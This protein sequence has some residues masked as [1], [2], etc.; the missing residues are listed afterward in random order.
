DGLRQPDGPLDCGNSGT[1]MR[2]LAGVLAGRPFPATLTGD[3]S[4]SS[5][6]MARVAEPLG[7][8]GATVGLT[9][10]HAPL[11]ITGG[12]LRG[13]E[14]RLPVA[15]AQVKSAVLLAGLQAEGTTTI[16]E[17][18]PS[19]DHTE[20]ML[21]LSVLELGTERY[22]TVEGGRRVP[23]GLWVVPRDF[24]AAAFFL[25]AGSIVE[26]ATLELTGV[27]LNPSRS[28]LL[29]VL[30][31]MGARIEVLNERE[32][33]REPLADLRIYTPKN[34][35]TGVEVGG[36][37]IPN[38]LDEIPLLAVAAA[39]A[40]G[41]T[42]IRDAAELRVKETDRL[43]ATAAFLTAMG[44]K[45]TEIID[46]LV[47]EGGHPLHGAAV[48]SH[49]DHRIAMAAGVA[50]LAASSPTTIHGADAAAISFPGFWT[51]LDGLTG[52]GTVTVV[53]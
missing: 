31:A 7:L 51:E 4:L 1:T 28:A 48:E 36:A 32:R 20:R 8:M 44:A 45:V 41:R 52:G 42:V 3:A 46:G 19:R 33:G 23:A 9:D 22:V 12:R 13:I 27:G 15:S 35:L 40:Q 34:G 16:I 11:T 37:L 5:R 53:D 18:A 26:N 25:V 24:S 49:G 38:L 29:D 43:A 50:A 21:G 30:T 17:T 2:L 14:Y 47:I 6:P 39:C 10:G